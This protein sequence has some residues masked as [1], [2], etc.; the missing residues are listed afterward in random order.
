MRI[1]SPHLVDR[2]KAADFAKVVTDAQA[3]DERFE[4]TTEEQWTWMAEMAR[5]DIAAGDLMSLEDFLANWT[6]EKSD[7]DPPG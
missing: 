4:A 2:S 3:W 1:N 6:P 7:D 5:K